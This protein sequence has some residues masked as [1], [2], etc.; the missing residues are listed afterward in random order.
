MSLLIYAMGSTRCR[1]RASLQLVPHANTATQP[2]LLASICKEADVIT[3]AGHI[4]CNDTNFGD[5][6]RVTHLV[7]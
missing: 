2:L 3:N 6:Y 1:I 5:N 7:G 4:G